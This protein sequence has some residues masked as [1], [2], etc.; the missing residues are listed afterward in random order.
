MTNE[1]TNTT[2]V[3]L[4]GLSIANDVIADIAGYTALESYGV[5]GMAAPNLQDGI[6]KILPRARLRRG[7]IVDSSET[8]VRVDL[9]VVIEYGTSIATVSKNLIDNVTFA[10]TD[11]ANVRIDT[12]EV[13]V[14]GVKTHN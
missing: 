8:G 1:V 14:Q 11:L 6:A 10:L 5:V 3:V 4:G 12:V 9:F 7:I 13:H 2:G